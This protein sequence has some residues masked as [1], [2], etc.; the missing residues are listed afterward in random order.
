[1]YEPNPL[2]MVDRVLESI[3]YTVTPPNRGHF[4]TSPFLRDCLIFCLVSPLVGLMSSID[5]V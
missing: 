3:N 5:S 1:M 2:V 4:G